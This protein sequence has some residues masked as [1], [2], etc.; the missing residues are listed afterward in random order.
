M[1]E[2]NKP[3]IS[4][5]KRPKVSE[6]KLNYGFKRT[7]V[8]EVIVENKPEVPEERL[9]MNNGPVYELKLSPSDAQSQPVL[10]YA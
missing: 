7:P 1:Q 6:R 2:A 9:G 10:T 5:A 4:R 3:R 8:H